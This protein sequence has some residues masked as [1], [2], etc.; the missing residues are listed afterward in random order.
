MPEIKAEAGTSAY[1]RLRTLRSKIEMLCEGNI[2]WRRN[3]GPL[4]LPV[5]FLAPQFGRLST[6]L[7]PWC[8][9]GI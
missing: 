6:L 4:A 7:V 9:N 1:Q 3:R 8:R 2:Q 5:M